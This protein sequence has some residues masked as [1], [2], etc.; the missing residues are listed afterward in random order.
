MSNM[1]KT[2]KPA[3][4]CFLAMTVLCGF[5]YTASGSGADPN[6]SPA[7]AEYQVGRIAKVRN[8]DENE[9]R[10]IIKAYTSGR[11]LGFIG[12]PAVNVLKVNLALDGL[13]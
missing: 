7:A 3:L 1:M 5:I 4:L 13:L 9:V 2:L 8:M 10:R 6:I 11:F 12:E